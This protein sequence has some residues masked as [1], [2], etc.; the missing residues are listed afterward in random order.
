MR[1]CSDKDTVMMLPS[2]DNMD[3]FFVYLPI[4]SQ[5]NQMFACYVEHNKHKV[6]IFTINI[7]N[8]IVS[9]CAF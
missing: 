3:I 7:V 8:E 5:S 2:P 4:L 6:T 9:V 1:I